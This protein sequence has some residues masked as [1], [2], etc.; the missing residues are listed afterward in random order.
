MDGFTTQW[1]TE[2]DYKIRDDARRFELYE[3]NR[4]LILGLG[5]AVE[6][7]LNIGVDRIWQRVQ[8]LANILRNQLRSIEGISVHDFGDE[9][10]GIVTFT[11]NEIDSAVIKAKL[12]EK[13]INVSVG[14]A[15]STLFFMN[16][17]HLSSVVRASVHYYNTEKE[18][19]IM[20]D[21]L[22]SL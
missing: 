7:A 6:Y 21:V 20:C 9:Q 8:Y 3:K 2:T 5:K 16:K 15:K 22:R 13:Q 11:V 12:A 10:C 1:V 4:A 14:L 17:N 18:I 19:I